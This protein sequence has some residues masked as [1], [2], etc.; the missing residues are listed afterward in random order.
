MQFQGRSTMPLIRGESAFDKDRVLMSEEFGRVR[1]RI[2]DRAL[3]FSPDGRRPDELYD[4][5][6]DPEE[7]EN[8]ADA[9]PEAV[10]QLKLPYF[11]MMK[12][13]QKLSALF[14]LVPGKKTHLDDEAI[15]QLKA[16]GY[17]DQ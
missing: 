1:V 17:L 15:E 9:N 16:L 6:T 7:I 14:V 11:K 5:Q 4:L 12:E 2:G 13:S 8:L 10:E 3:N